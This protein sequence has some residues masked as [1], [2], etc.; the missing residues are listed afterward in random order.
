MTR[1]EIKQ[2]AHEVVNK[3]FHGHKN[4]TVLQGYITRDSTDRL[5]ISIGAIPVK[6]DIGAWIIADPDEDGDMMSIDRKLFPQVKWSDKT[7]L[8]VEITIKIK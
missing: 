5:D 6:S 2:W 1:K 3:I 8:E 4:E 7:P